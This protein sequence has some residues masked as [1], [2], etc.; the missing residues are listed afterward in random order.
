MSI[1]SSTLTVYEL[2]EFKRLFQSAPLNGVSYVT[3]DG[4]VVDLY[5]PYPIDKAKALADFLNA[6]RTGWPRTVLEL[7]SLRRERDEF[8][9]QLDALRQPYRFDSIP[10]MS[11]S[12]SESAAAHDPARLA[13]ATWRE[14]D[15]ESEDD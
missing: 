15:E 14:R 6:A 13:P 9:A 10:F 11:Q 12:V 2:S 7:E 8:R 3:A 4:G 5:G 1:E